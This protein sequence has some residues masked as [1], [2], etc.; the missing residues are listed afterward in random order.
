[1]TKKSDNKT[2]GIR[3]RFWTNDLPEKVGKNNKQIPC[4]NSGVVIIEANKTKGVASD[5]EVFHYIDDVPRAV[6]EI[7]KRSKIALVEDVAYTERAK[8]RNN[9]K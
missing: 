5:S 8:K 1:M 4:W 9:K 2:I 3:L 6:K 7:M